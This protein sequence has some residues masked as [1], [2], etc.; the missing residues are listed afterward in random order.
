MKKRILEPLIIYFI[1]VCSSC[2]VVLQPAAETREIDNATS[3]VEAATTGHWN[4]ITT[5]SGGRCI[6]L[7][8]QLPGLPSGKMVGNASFDIYFDDRYSNRIGPTDSLYGLP[9]RANSTITLEDYFEGPFWGDT[10]DAVGIQDNLVEDFDTEGAWHS[11][12]AFGNYRLEKYIQTQYDNGAQGGDWIF[13]RL[14]SEAKNYRIYSRHSYASIYYQGGTPESPSAYS[15]YISCDFVDS[16]SL[17]TD[18]TVELG[19]SPELKPG[20]S[21]SLYTAPIEHQSYYLHERERLGYNPRFGLN[22]VQFDSNNI[23][24]IRQKPAVVCTLDSSNSWVQ[25]DFRLILEDAFPSWEGSFGEF[26]SPHSDDRIVFDDDDDA[27]LVINLTNLGYILMHS[28]D[29][30]RTWQLY[31]LF[32]SM[33]NVKLEYR[34]GHNDLSKP[35][36][37]LLRTIR[38]SDSPSLD[39][40]IPTKNSD[41]SLS[42]SHKIRIDSSTYK[43]I[44]GGLNTP[45]GASNLSAT[46]GNKIHVAYASRSTAMG[47]GTPFFARTYDRGTGTLSSLVYL[48]NA[49]RNEPDVHN[50]PGIV[51]DSNGYLHVILAAHGSYHGQC[52]RYRKSTYINDSSNWGSIVDLPSGLSYLTFLC[53]LN[54]NMYVVAH[55]NLADPNLE[56]RYLI[57]I[58][59]PAGQSWDTTKNNLIIPFNDTSYGYIYNRFDSRLNMDRHGNLYLSYW[60]G[61]GLYDDSSVQQKDSFEMKW[62]CW[63]LILESEGDPWADPNRYVTPYAEATSAGMIV[64]K[65]AGNTWTLAVTEDFTAEIKP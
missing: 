51:L 36:V 1:V 17:L 8:F 40:A 64:S 59:K 30:C 65:D 26:A 57:Y 23:P 46:L 34:S 37:M 19:Q 22:S 13:L 24:F 42:L 29:K 56:L 35:P 33:S 27:Y 10:N 6:V 48:G 47:D 32:K 63:S 2:G 14:N 3:A 49:G 60:N 7:A 11:T 12:D 41:G 52:F 21:S 4:V 18:E 20:L 50:R 39:L 44:G 16:S 45:M 62:P 53:D 5:S 55:D 9:Y 43:A 54:D 25:R 15:P 61:M 38:P 58:K 28:T 31:P